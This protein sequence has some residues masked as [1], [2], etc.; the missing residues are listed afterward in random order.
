MANLYV[1]STTGSDANGGTNWG[2]GNAKATLAGAGAIDAAGDHIWVAA[3]HAESTA[4]NVTF[5]FAGTLASPTWVI[6]ATTA[7]APPTTGATSATVTT[8]GASTIT[9]SAASCYMAGIQFNIGSGANTGTMVFGGASSWQRYENCK[10]YTVATG[11]NSRHQIGGSGLTP[12][13]IEWRDCDVKFANAA[14]GFNLIAGFLE[15]SGGSVASGGTSP[16]SLFQI[17]SANQTIGVYVHDVDLSN[18]ANTVTLCVGAHPGQSAIFENC[19]LPSGWFSSGSLSGVTTERGRVELLNCS[20]GSENYKTIIQDVM[21]TVRDE[22]TLIMSGANAATDGTTGQSR[23]MVS[24]TSCQWPHQPLRG[25]EMRVWIDSTGSSKT[26][27]V[28]ILRDN[29]TGLTNAEF[30]IEVRYLGS[31]SFPIGS[32]GTS[33]A[34]DVFATPSTLSSSSETWTTTGMANPN[35]QKASVSI[36]PNMKGWFTVTPMLAKASTT[37]YYNHKPIVT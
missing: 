7:A 17:A 33:R 3:A 35:K 2:G 28:H 16:S 15:W 13:R 34:A 5:G 32:I 6:C 26:V 20:D 27:D 21:G 19:K 12:A 8:T 1:D 4:G 24:G 18:L 23:K 10:F 30:W 9:N 36:T 37:M 29:A 11:T 25:K 14:H 31:S 22:T